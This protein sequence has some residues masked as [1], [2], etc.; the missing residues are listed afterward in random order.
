MDTSFLLI[1][2]AIAGAV[3]GWITGRMLKSISLSAV[4][5]VIVG[6]LGGIFVGLALHTTFPDITG[7]GSSM[8]LVGIVSAALVGGGILTATC[9]LVKDMISPKSLG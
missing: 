7:S 5:N 3:G 8:P 4:A 9:A 2:E 6:L 1:C